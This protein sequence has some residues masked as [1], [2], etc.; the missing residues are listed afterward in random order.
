MI[1]Y[2]LIVAMLALIA[3]MAL[4]TVGASTG[5]TFEAADRALAGASYQPICELGS[6]TWPGCLGG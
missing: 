3:A 6:P 1:E 2:A 5:K 4:P